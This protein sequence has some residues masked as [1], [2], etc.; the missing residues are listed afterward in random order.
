MNSGTTIKKL[1][2]SQLA[3]FD[4]EFVG[5]EKKAAIKALIDQDFSSGKIRFLD[6]GGGNG[7]F[8]DWLL[9]EYPESEGVVLDNSESLLSL[10]SE[11]RR[12]TVSAI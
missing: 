2:D 4:W 6:V 11:N 8:A 1:D 12:K 7:V 10:N 5:D 9:S 3:G